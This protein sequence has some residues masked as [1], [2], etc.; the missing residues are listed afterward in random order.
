ML[1]FRV[2][3][4]ILVSVACFGASPLQTNNSE[5][6]NKPGAPAR[7]V[8]ASMPMMPSV[9]PLFLEGSGFSSTLHLVNETK[10]PLKARID[11]FSVYG[12]REAGTELTIPAFGLHV[13]QVRD[14]LDASA[15]G[16]D[17]GSIRV[18]A[19]QNSDGLL[20]VLTFTHTGRGANNYFDE[21]LL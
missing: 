6:A 9:A 21:E 1:P 18:S 5:P 4:L 11:V 3:V 13:V 8:K 20:A 10:F 15:A 19:D 14:L 7:I 16:L 2:A 12:N 17:I